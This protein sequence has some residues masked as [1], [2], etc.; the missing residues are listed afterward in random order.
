MR[1]WPQSRSPNPTPQTCKQ[2]ATGLWLGCIYPF[3]LS[4]SLSP[5]LA[6]S[7]SLSLTLS[8]S[9]QTEPEVRILPQ[10]PSQNLKRQMRKQAATGLWLGF[11]LISYANTCDI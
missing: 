2:A 1:I 10:S 5:S 6:L 11:V 4:L 8:L 3:S 7:R 9:L